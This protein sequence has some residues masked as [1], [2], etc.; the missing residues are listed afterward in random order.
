MSDH[1]LEHVE[2][3]LGSL[4]VGQKELQQAMKASDERLL[5]HM[6][7]MFARFSTRGGGH[8]DDVES[9]RGSHHSLSGGCSL[10]PKITKLDFPRY[11]GMDDPTGWIC[12]VEQFFEFQSTEEA[13]K[14]LMASYHL[15]DNVQLWYQRF[16]NRREGVNWEVFNYELHLRYGPSR[17]QNFFGDFTKLKQTGS[18]RDYQMDF[19][20]L[21][22][23]AGH[24]SEEQQV[25]CFVSRLKDAI[26]VDV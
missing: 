5:K 15:D 3:E 6:E 14:L 8:E 12:R 9:S 1:R 23:R 2:N 4:A 25:G 26:Q 24:L 13:E 17:Y 7:T 18:I 16:K 10:A 19:D 22:H 20:R 21:L 11:N